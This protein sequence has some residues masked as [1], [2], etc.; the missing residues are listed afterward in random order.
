MKKTRWLMTAL[1]FSI[2]AI[3]IIQVAYA[4]N[5]SDT[6]FE[7]SVGW[8]RCDYS[9]FRA[10]TDSSP[11]YILI[12]DGP[13][14]TWIWVVNTSYVHQN[15]GSGLAQVPPNA[16]R[17]IHTNV[18]ENG[19]GSCAIGSE[20]NPIFDDVKGVWSPDSIGSYTYAN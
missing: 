4:S 20:Y 17:L 16:P 2:I 19:Y 5:H 6:D 10:K 12:T 18:Y 15:S 11:V 8:D 1:V 7:L 14:I 3:G 13:G 9:D